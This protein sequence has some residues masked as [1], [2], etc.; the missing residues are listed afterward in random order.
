MQL[1][2]ISHYPV[3]SCK[4]VETE[5]CLIEERGIRHDRRYVVIDQ[6]NL[7]VTG[8][9]NSKLPLLHVSATDQGL[10]ISNDGGETFSIPAPDAQM[11]IREIRIWDDHVNAWDLG[12]TVAQQMSTALDQNVR[13]VYMD[14]SIIRDIEADWPHDEVAPVSFADNYPILLVNESS[15]TALSELADDHLDTRRFRSNFTITGASAWDEDEWKRIKIGDIRFEVAMP[16]ARCKFTTLDPDSAKVH[17]NQEPLRTLAR[18]RRG[19]DGDLYFGQYLVPLNTG[20]L[21]TGDP[22]I[23][24]ERGPRRP[25]LRDN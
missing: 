24:E 13:V 6:N 12:D 25:T 22:L 8:R 4:S 7:T 16:C 18:H 21:R 9:D 3:K 10:S 1:N 14:D 23:V 2:K 11:P 17:P 15:T 19:Q 5:S 20:E